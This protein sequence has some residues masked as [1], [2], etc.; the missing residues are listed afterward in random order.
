MDTERRY[1]KHC[2]KMVGDHDGPII[3]LAIYMDRGWDIAVR[4][5]WFCGKEN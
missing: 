1:C 2:K 5:C 3:N 4:T